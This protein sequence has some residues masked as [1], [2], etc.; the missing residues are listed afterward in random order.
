M[1]F[2][3]EDILCLQ[4]LF[5]SQ[6]TEKERIGIV[7]LGDKMI[8]HSQCLFGLRHPVGDNLCDI[9]FSIRFCCHIS[10]LALQ[11]VLIQP[12]V[13]MYL[14]QGMSLMVEWPALMASTLASGYFAAVHVDA[15][16]GEAG[17]GEGHGQG[18]TDIAQADDGDLGGVGMDFVEKLVFHGLLAPF[19]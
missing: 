6:M 17:L 9:Q 18:Q 4:Y 8:S 13:K 14:V 7:S 15:N 19:M 10:K 5:N 3:P 11:F 16:H 1:F 2:L 12:F